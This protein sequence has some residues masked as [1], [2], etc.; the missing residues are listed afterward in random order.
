MSRSQYIQFLRISPFFSF[1]IKCSLF[2]MFTVSVVG[3]TF[4]STDP[5]EIHGSDEFFSKCS[6]YYVRFCAYLRERTPLKRYFVVTRLVT[7]FEVS[8]I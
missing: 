6:T 5:A 7:D 8:S 3:K 4:T 2:I 1:S